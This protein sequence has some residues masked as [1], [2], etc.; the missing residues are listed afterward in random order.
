M[1]ETTDSKVSENLKSSQFPSHEMIEAG[2]YAA[3]EHCLGLPIEDLV[4]SVFI[5]MISAQES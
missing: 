1:K 3:N 5:A 2:I 4:R